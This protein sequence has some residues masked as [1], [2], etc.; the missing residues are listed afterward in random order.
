LN[1]AYIRHFGNYEKVA[2]SFQ[3]LMF[4]AIKNLTLKLKPTTL[5]IL[6]DNPDLTKEP[7]IRFDACVLI[8][9]KIQPKGQVGYKKIKGG[10]FAVFRYKGPYDNFY[11]VYDYIYNICL[12][13]YQWELRDEPALE[14]YIK[15]P[16][17]HK[18]KDLVTDFYLPIV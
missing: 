9:K 15:S 6:H 4:W 17:F 1:L 13:R 11:P 16:P 12:F 5:G 7:N 3:R 8:T 14:W 10:K 18:P 2:K